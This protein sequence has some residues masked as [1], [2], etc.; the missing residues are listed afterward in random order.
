MLQWI[1]ANL[2]TI[3]ICVVLAVTVMLI[4]RYL[5]RQK[6]QGKSSCGCNCAHCAMH[7]ACHSKK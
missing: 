4:I 7:G 3:F 5:V 1:V 2:A 6:Q